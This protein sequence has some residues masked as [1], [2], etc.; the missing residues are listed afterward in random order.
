MRWSACLAATLLSVCVGVPLSWTLRDA[1]G[2]VDRPTQG[3]AVQSGPSDFVYLPAVMGVDSDSGPVGIEAQV[4][5]VL[6]T[7]RDTLRVQGMSLTDVVSANV[8]LADA[9]DFAAMNSAYRGFFGT[10]PPPRATVQLD[11]PN[12]GARVQIAVVAARPH[13]TRNVIAPEG[14]ASP[15]LPYSWAVLARNTL[16]VAGLTS[17]DPKTYQPVIGNVATQTRRALD[18]L[19]LILREAGMDYGDVVSCTVYLD[20]ARAFGAMNEVYASFFTTAPPARATVRAR[21]TNPGFAVEIQ[22]V[23]AQ[24][25]SRHVVPR[26]A[27]AQR[28]LP[29]SPAI[30]VGNRLFLAGMVGSGPD[31][32]AKGDVAA[33][34][35]Q[36]LENLRATL[37][38]AE[39]SFDHVVSTTIFVAD[40]RHADAVSEVYAEALPAHREARTTVGASLMSPDALVEI[41]MVAERRR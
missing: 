29:F 21:L 31:G 23:A 30:Q 5:Q 34:T 12:P 25:D 2:S 33:Q 37:T 10:A 6:E 19:G 9:R 3:A 18:N 35:W 4:R 40:A 24:D 16:F 36:T 22:C 41:T 27:G 1:D 39:M 8:Y 14:I 13:V 26:S 32:L 17:R 11:L 7:V 15:E 38:A 28:Q 20:D